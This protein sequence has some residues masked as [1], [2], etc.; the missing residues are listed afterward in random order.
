[1]RKVFNVSS[2]GVMAESVQL[3]GDGTYGKLYSTSLDSA[4]TIIEKKLRSS[5]IL[6]PQ[7]CNIYGVYITPN[8]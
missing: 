8:S 3:I 2:M 5:S 6:I 7:S 4:A 1:M